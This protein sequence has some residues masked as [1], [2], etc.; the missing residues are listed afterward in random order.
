MKKYLFFCFFI[1]SIIFFGCPFD[2]EY[3]LGPGNSDS[4]NSNLIGTWE[5]ITDTSQ[6]QMMEV[7][8]YSNSTMI[9]KATAIGSKSDMYL[10]EEFYVK[11]AEVDN[12]KY[13]LIDVYD[14]WF[15]EYFYYYVS[16]NLKNENTLITK[17]VAISP[18]NNS[19]MT[20]TINS[21]LSLY[22]HFLAYQNKVDFFEN[23]LTW[24]KKQ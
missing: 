7:R 3:D 16:Y 15:D 1:I 6:I 18:W 10:G 5:N 9:I 19:E 11:T 20:D 8:S 2:S 22:H 4:F 24:K 13:L 14:D 23:T 17:D 12:T 21:S